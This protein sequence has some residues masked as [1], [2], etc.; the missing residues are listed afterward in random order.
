M[1]AAAGEDRLDVIAGDPWLQSAD[2]AHHLQR[3]RR[4]QAPVSGRI[5]GPLHFQAGLLR[6]QIAEAASWGGQEGLQ[7]D[8]P[9]NP[10]ANPIGDARSHEASIAEADQNKTIQP[11]LEHQLNNLVDVV[12]QPD[13][14][15]VVRRPLTYTAEAGRENPMSG[16]PK[17][18]YRSE[19]RS[20]RAFCDRTEPA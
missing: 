12:R 10:A 5:G 19:A 11:F 4:D 2:A 14:S 8:Q 13:V 18:K 7:I 20:V 15:A 3:R 9:R 6:Q 16:R 17:P 1:E